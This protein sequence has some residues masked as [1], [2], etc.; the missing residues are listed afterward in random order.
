M[1]TTTLADQLGKMLYGMTPSEAH[2]QG[3]CIR[4]KKPPQF[5]TDDGREEY[6]LSALCEECFDEE[7][8]EL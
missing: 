6:R 8:A 7:F 3:L 1:A 5:K 4:C 2:R